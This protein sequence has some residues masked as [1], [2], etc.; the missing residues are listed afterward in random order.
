MAWLVCGDRPDSKDW[1]LFA[2]LTP[3]EPPTPQASAAQKVGDPVNIDGLTG[4]IHNLFR[5]S[6]KHLDNTGSS[7]WHTGDVQYGY[8][9]QSDYNLLEVRWNNGGIS[10]YHGKNIPAKDV[11]DFVAAFTAAN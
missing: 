10:L 4:T 6:V 3:V 7:G 9:A 11:K 1:A 5:Y 8:T 2:P